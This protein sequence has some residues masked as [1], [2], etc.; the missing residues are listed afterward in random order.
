MRTDSVEELETQP[1]FFMQFTTDE[2]D[3]ALRV[4]AEALDGI[5]KVEV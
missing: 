5:Y 2:S 1:A 3:E 4:S